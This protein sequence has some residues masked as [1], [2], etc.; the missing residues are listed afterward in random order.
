[1]W[2]V[3]ETQFAIISGDHARQRV[4]TRGEQMAT[5]ARRNRGLRWQPGGRPPDAKVPAQRPAAA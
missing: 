2:N 3:A 1:M 4:A 5:A